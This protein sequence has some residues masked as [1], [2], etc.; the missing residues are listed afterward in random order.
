MVDQVINVSSSLDPN[1]SAN[2]LLNSSS[3][4][5]LPSFLTASSTPVGDGSG[6]S[7]TFPV[8]L[9]NTTVINNFGTAFGAE[10]DVVGLTGGLRFEQLSIAQGSGDKAS[11]TIVRNPNT[12]DILAILKN[13]NA[14]TVD[15]TS[16]VRLDDDFNVIQDGVTELIGR[17]ILPASTFAVGPT[18]GQ[19]LALN[20]DGTTSPVNSNGLPVP[21]PT[22]NGQPVQ[23]FSAILPGPKVGTYLVMVD[24]GYGTKANS[25]D[26]LLRFY[27]VE[28]DFATG[29]VYPVNLQTG[30]RL[31][32]FTSDSFFQLNDKNNK[33]KG[34]QTIVAD[35]DTYPGSETV[36]PGGI[37]VDPAIKQGRLLTGADFDL[38]SFRRV[39]DGTYWF[40][41]EFGPYLLHVGADGTLLDAPIATPNLPQLGSNSLIQTPDNPAFANLPEAQ[42]VASANL[43]RSKGF[44]G[45]ALS[46]DG[47]KLYTLLEGPV[48]ADADQRRLLIYEFDLKTKQY[49]G[50]YY[51]YRM[52][53][54]FPNR[55][56]GDMTA[57]NDHEFLIL[58][59]D[60]GQGD[61]SNPAFTNPARSKKVYKIDINKLDA[62]GYVDKELI[63]DELN[64]S[65]PNGLGGNGTQNGVFTFPFVTIEDILPIDNQTLLIANDNNYPF[66]V[67][68]TPGQADNNEFIQ[69]RLNQPL[70]LHTAFQEGVSAGDVN[71]SSA[72]LW[73][74]TENQ[75]TQQGIAAHLTA[76]VSTDSQF[77]SNV[78]TFDGSTDPSRDY[79]L[80]L[81]ADGLQSGTQYYYRFKT[82]NGDISAVGTFK[83]APRPDQQAE[84]RFG[85]SG[86]ADGQWRP[87]GSLLGLNQ[88]NLDYFVFLGDTIYETKNDRSPGTADPFADPAQALADYE[89]KYREN[90]QATNIG[91]FP[92]TQAL[93]Q[94]QGIYALLDN[95]ELGNKQFI[96]GGAPTGDPAGKGV[97][98]TDSTFD[99]NTT[100]SYINQTTGFNTLLQAYNTYQPIRENT[101]YS[102]NDPRSNGT[103]QLYYAQQWGANSIFI[104]ADDRSY[105][106]IRMKTASG[107][108]DTGSRADNPDRT[109]LG[110]T[111]LAWLEQTLLDAQAKGTPWKFVAISSPIDQ[112]GVIGDQSAISVT[113]GNFTTGSDGG[114]SWIGE[115]RAERNA[116]L[117][118][119][120]DHHIT[121]VVF[122]STDDHQTRINELDYSP[123]GQTA[124]QSTYVR[125]PGNVFEIV[126]GPIGAGGPDGVTDH[127][128]ANIKSIADSLA[129][130]QLSYGIDPIGLAANYPGLHDVFRE[131]DP[132]ANTA[133]QAIDFYSPDTFNYSILDVSPDGKTLTVNLYGINSYAANTFPEPSSSNPV[134]RIL[135][136][137]VDAIAPG[138]SL[139]NGVAAGD[140]TQTSSVLWTHST[141]PGTVTFQ[142]STNPSFAA[143]Q[144]ATATVTSPTQPVK[145]N[146]D[147]LEPG[148]VYYYRATDAVGASAAG[149]F[150]TADALGTHS[151]LSFGVSGDWR[152]EL[153]P[154]PAIANAPSSNL[155]FF[156]EFGDTI[157]ADYPSPAVPNA[158]ARTLT[159][160]ENKHNEVYSDRYGL[161]AWADLRS[162]TAILATI[163]DHEVTDNFAGGAPASSDSRFQDTTPDKLI[164]DTQLYQNGLQAFQEYNPIQDLF[165]SNTGDPT[166]DGE[167]QL[168]RYNT[169]GSDAAVF[170]L[171]ERTFRSQ[172]LEDVTDP[173]DPAQV[174]AFLA[175]SFN[176]NRTVLGQAQLSQL[177]HDLSDA[178]SKGIT[179]KF[180]MVPE[181]IENLGI[182]AAADRYEGYAAERNALLK[183]IDDN[184]IQNVVFVSADIHGTLV[185]NLTYQLAPGTPQIPTSAFEVTT[186]PV[187][188]DAP[189]GPTV[190]GLAAQVGLLTPQQ[191]AV[192][193]SLPAVGKDAFVR[194]LVDSGLTPLGYDPVGLDNN[195]PQANGLINAKLL[196]GS[197]VATQYYGWTKFDI[198]PDT[199]K[200]T[201]TTYGIPYYTQAELTANPNAILSRTP[202]IVSQFEV[203]P[204]A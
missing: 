7:K 160:Y 196:Q 102:P 142:Y 10:K 111:Q 28:P 72:I 158:Q 41:E 159:E 138:A 100:G 140:T 96:N 193:N 184:H 37:P 66:S 116:L 190:I 36:Q 203:T 130:Q 80:K 134:R 3:P 114:K 186:G 199:Q 39:A 179:W 202:Q 141:A 29:N 44:E 64:I 125:V 98:A 107:A 172:E 69:I 147:G 105:R 6:G 47:T 154:Y 5:A 75:I 87:Y 16:F 83:T 34:F 176:P 50:K 35:L 4:L 95:H 13:V 58:E 150:R 101:V 177:E 143:A 24:N 33:L 124:D 118:F 26:S 23:G 63:A 171:D 52:D 32:S 22:P 174:G 2:R 200:L 112:I 166:I 149:Q 88:Q 21:F 173:N 178:Q 148:T 194:Q 181:P 182:L 61:A 121:N 109:M 84:V 15:D 189:F 40:G 185:N 38:E 48:T 197:Y 161:N 188:F 46:A 90:L 153:S 122:L 145:V 187:A 55:A 157:Y 86:D 183:Y 65:D 76:Q 99:V 94:S 204:K 137:S 8:T 54:A 192:Y 79:T 113:N 11:D 51:S 19:F 164:R 128:F 163:D 89:R 30:Q 170:T 92:G 31:N 27:A 91:G 104:N 133:R 67:G 106:D 169:F 195:L 62:D 167:R 17:A 18:S 139:P 97:D 1:L 14:N 165:Y 117:K 108:D 155:Q 119:I 126:D 70:D 129:R 180:I 74:R 201:V 144:T 85:F 162:S 93:Y 59:R 53:G 81:E 152:G 120:A 198:S 131:G 136:F 49:T 132:N 175:Q 110:A 9:G 168:Y 77:R 60:N 43:P 191:Q 115:Y 123:T 56:I 78:L 151:G 82:D 68:R 25:P 103:Q 156:L 71:D 127:S 12:G 45:M 57:I 146:I 135:G 42:K 73:T 20:N